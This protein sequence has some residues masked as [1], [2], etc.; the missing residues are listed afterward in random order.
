VVTPASTID[1]HTKAFTWA[2]T[3][4][5]PSRTNAKSRVRLEPSTD[6]WE[7]VAAIRSPQEERRR[8]CEERQDEGHAEQLGHPEERER[9]DPRLKDGDG[10]GQHEQLEQEAPRGQEEPLRRQLAR[11]TPRH[12]QVAKES[13]EDEQLHRRR[14]LDERQVSSGVF[15]DHG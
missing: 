15:E 5:R 3:P 14:P 2:G 4:R 9:G 6:S 8:D 7:N 1:C 13:E 11:D 12:E 10:G